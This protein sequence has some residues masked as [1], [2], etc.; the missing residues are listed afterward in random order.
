MDP[1]P[2]LRQP[3]Y[4][5]LLAART[6]AMLA[7]AYAP[8]ALA[9]G[10]L[11]LPGRDAMDLSVIMAC[12]LAP[13]V[14]LVLFGGAVAD[15]HSRA[16]V[17]A[18]GE[19]GVGLS[20]LAAGAL[21]LTGD[22][23]L[24]ALG[25]AAA[26]AGVF[27][28]AVYPALTGVIPDLVPKSQLSQ[29]N[30]Y[31]QGASATARLLGVVSGGAVVAFLGGGWALLG[32]AAVYLVSAALTTRVPR[33]SKTVSRSEPMLRQILAGWD[34]FRSRQWLWVGVLAWGLMFFFFQGSVGVLGPVIAKADY[35]GATTWSLVLAGNATG[36]IVGVFV[37]MAWWPKRPI[38]TGILLSLGCGFP[39]MLLGAS[40]PIWTVVAAG[41]LMGLGFQLFTVYWLTTMQLEVPAQALSRVAA[42]D[43]FG[44]IMLGPLGLVAAGPA[45]RLM[46]AHPAIAVAGAACVLIPALA[47]LSPQVRSLSTARR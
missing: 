4:R 29:A 24:W 30:A 8:V 3:A 2:L 47:L 17:I 7:F 18:L 39:L 34:E 27:G 38:R 36:A 13:E 25:L 12:Q 26:G 10:V 43:A 14:L 37:A 11:D 1:P 42:Y 9:F 44:S 35:S 31:L 23:P 20:W 6:L 19:A 46:G 40:A 41:V 21:L 32:A 28:S 45:E 15:R 33:E 16:V 22:P 5:T